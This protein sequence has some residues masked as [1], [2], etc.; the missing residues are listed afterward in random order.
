[1]RRARRDAGLTQAALA[2][3][4]EM[5][6][7]EI[8]RLERPGANPRA[9]TLARVLEATGHRLEVGPIAAP[10]VDLAQLDRHLA[11][12]PAERLRAHDAAARSVGALR[13]GARRVR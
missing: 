8:A 1:M 4:L 13:R 7:P 6:Q 5:S 10:A 3:R 12:T 2:R 11:M 9:E